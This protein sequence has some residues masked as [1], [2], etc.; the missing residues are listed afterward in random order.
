MCN[1]DIIKNICFWFGWSVMVAAS[2]MQSPV[3]AINGA[4]LVLTAFIIQHHITTSDAL[5]RIITNQEQ[6]KKQM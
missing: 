5:D 6:W 4:V 2:V 1:L 3:V